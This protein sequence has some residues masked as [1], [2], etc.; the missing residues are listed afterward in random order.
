MFKIQKMIG[1]DTLNYT[2]NTIK[3]NAALFGVLMNK[4][5]CGNLRHHSQLLIA[6]ICQSYCS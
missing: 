2:G 6:P 5:C 1:Y 4:L 3:N